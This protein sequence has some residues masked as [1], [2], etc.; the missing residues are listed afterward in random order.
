VTRCPASTGEIKGPRTTHI[1][2]GFAY[3]G[4]AIFFLHGFA[5]C[6]RDAKMCEHRALRRR[7]EIIREKSNGF[8]GGVGRNVMAHS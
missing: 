6:E 7:K 8:D 4:Y 3:D 2:F 1:D 5:S